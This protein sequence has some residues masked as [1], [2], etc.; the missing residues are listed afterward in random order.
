M[1]FSAFLF[2]SCACPWKEEKKRVSSAPEQIFKAERPHGLGNGGGEWLG[3]ELLSAVAVA[4]STRHPSSSSSSSSSFRP[5][6][7]SIR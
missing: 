3:L 5:S 6:L 4:A 1:H 7:L 2:F